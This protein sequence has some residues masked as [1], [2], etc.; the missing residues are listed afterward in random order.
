MVHAMSSSPTMVRVATFNVSM[1]ASNYQPKGSELSLAVLKRELASGENPQIKNIAEIIQRVRPDILLLNEFDYIPEPSEGIELFQKHYLYRAQNKAVTGIEYPYIY[2]GPV[3]TGEPSPFDLSGD[4]K[5][6]GVG[7]DAWGFGNYPGQYGMVVLSR[8]PI[9][10]EKVRSFQRFKWRDMPG[11]LKPV[12]PKTNRSWYSDEAWAEFRLSSKSLWDLPIAVAGQQVHLLASHP[13]PPVFDGPENRNGKR[14][15]DEIRLL[16]DYLSGADYL[17]D[18]SG[19]KALFTGRRFVILGDLNASEHSRETL[20]GTMQQL[21]KHAKVDAGFTPKSEGGALNAPGDKNAAEHTAGW[22]SRADYI[23]PSKAGWKV[24]GGGV[25][26]PLKHEPEY[27]LIA[28]RKA[29]SDHRM[30]Y[31]DLQIAPITKD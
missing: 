29:S 3:N 7:V 2:L 28:S 22:K 26:W 27:R 9:V 12:D 19:S 23:L 31:L 4:G 20:P 16:A 6:S 14:N 24:A 30:V 11:A 5:A 17:Y 18:D 1:D 8:Y 15:H 25:F 21:L 10:V 13:T